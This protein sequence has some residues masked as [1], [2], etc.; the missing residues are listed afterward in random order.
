[1]VLLYIHILNLAFVLI[2]LMQSALDESYSKFIVWVRWSVRS[3]KFHAH[4]ICHHEIIALAIL[5]P[6]HFK[7][8]AFKQMNNAKQ[9]I[10][11]KNK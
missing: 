7:M 1:M 9:V 11:T 10:K 6:L 4:Y 3:E 5:A 2:S 8:I